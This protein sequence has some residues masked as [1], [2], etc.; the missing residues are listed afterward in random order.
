MPS[1]GHLERNCRQAAGAEDE[2]RVRRR[3]LEVREDLGREPLDALDEHRLPL[4]VRA[5]DL[6][7]EGHRELHDRVKPRIGAVAGEELLDRDPRVTGAEGVDKPVGGD[8]VR[9]DAAR[10]VECVLLRRFDALEELPSGCQEAVFGPCRHSSSLAAVPAHRVTMLGTGL[11][12][13]FYTMALHGVRSRDQV[14]VVYSRSRDR[15]QK[16][17]NGTLPEIGH[18]RGSGNPGPRV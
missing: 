14:Q 11:I 10:V 8:C 18:S 5:H 15:V 12:G 7:V 16:F 1:H 2:Q 9:A 4:A 6:R 3:E 17:H 13:M